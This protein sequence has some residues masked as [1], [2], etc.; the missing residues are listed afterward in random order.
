MKIESFDTDLEFNTERVKIKTVLESSFSKELRILLSK[1]QLM[2]EHKAPYP[3]IIH[4]LSGVIDFGVD[5]SQ[6][7]LKQGDLITLD[8]NVPHNLLAIEK[9]V[10]R[11]SLSKNDTVDRVN[12]VAK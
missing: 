1:G 9:S 7:T 4:I 12:D 6:Y 11:L 8:S 5:G 2:K 3:I 10:V